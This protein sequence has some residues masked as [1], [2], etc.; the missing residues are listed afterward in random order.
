[1][2]FPANGQ[3]NSKFQRVHIFKGH[4]EIWWVVF[5]IDIVLSI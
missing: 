3:D 1:M 4:T 2:T 5:D